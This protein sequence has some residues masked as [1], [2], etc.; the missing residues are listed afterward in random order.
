[1]SRLRQIIINF[2]LFFSL[3]LYGCSI[4]IEKTFNEGLQFAEESDYTKAAE[5][6]ELVLKHEPEHF[7][8]IVGLAKALYNL[9]ETERAVELYK[10]AIEINPENPRV[11]QSLAWIYLNTNR[12]KEAKQLLLRALELDPKYSR[13]YID[14]AW[15]QLNLKEYNE[16]LATTE[17]VLQL[18]QNFPEPYY[19]RG[20]AASA[21]KEYKIAEEAFKNVILLSPENSITYL[22]YAQALENLN[23]IPEAIKNYRLYINLSD[24]D[25]SNLENLK[26]HVAQ[27]EEQAKK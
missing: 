13:A 2:L 10:R 1:M 8:S 5:K 24:M 26:K 23:K 15:T 14:L 18:E 7:D 12:L 17:K 3:F 19:I 16:V 9:G 22:Y 4:D 11:Y 27:L 21:I 20:I 25:N 6:F